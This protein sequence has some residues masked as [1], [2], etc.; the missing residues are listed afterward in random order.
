MAWGFLRKIKDG[1]VKGWNKVIKPVLGTVAKVAK[2][3]ADVAGGLLNKVKPGL[4][5]AVQK[6]AD[7]IDNLVNKRKSV[8][9]SRLSEDDDD[10]EG[11]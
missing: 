5:T 7:I 11:D 9:F 3:V 1:L 8:R 10:L 6:G 2:P 4:G